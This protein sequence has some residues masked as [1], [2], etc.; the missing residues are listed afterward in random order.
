MFLFFSRK[1]NQEVLFVKNDKRDQKIRA[2]QWLVLTRNNSKQKNKGTD[3]HTG[4]SAFAITIFEGDC[5]NV[6][7]FY[8]TV[9]TDSF[10]YFCA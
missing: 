3:Y 9:L 10:Q 5:L 1:S 8:Y 6:C 2:S 4:N 7:Q